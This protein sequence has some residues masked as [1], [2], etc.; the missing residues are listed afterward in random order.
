MTIRRRQRLT[1]APGEPS[2]WPTGPAGTPLAPGGSGRTVPHLSRGRRSARSRSGST[3]RRTRR[4]A[5]ACCSCCRAWTPPARAAWSSTSSAWSPAGRTHHVVQEAD[6]GGARAPFPVADP[7]GVAGGRDDR[8]L[9][10][11]PLRGRAG[12]AGARAGAGRSGQRRTPRSTVRGAARRPAARRSSSASCTSRTTSARR[13]LAR[14]DDPTK[15]WKFSEGD[16]AER[17]CWADYQAATGGAQALL[18]PTTR[19]GTWSRPT[20]SGT[21]TGRSPG[22]CTRPCPTSTRTTRRRSWTS[23]A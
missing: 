22:C 18:H 21:A 16:I 9:R 19:R 2:A 10:P 23:A 14:L 11:V 6:P 17:A 12:R 3:R 7:P 13:L 15:H 4:R 8:H 5:G 20:A 1:G